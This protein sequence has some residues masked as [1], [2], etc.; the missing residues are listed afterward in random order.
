MCYNKHM[1]AYRHNSELENLKSVT[2]FLIAANVLW[3]L[4]VTV[5]GPTESSDVLIRW[6]ALYTPYVEEGAW[7]RLLSCMFL[8]SGIRHLMNNMITLFALGAML[9]NEAGPVKYMLIYFLGGIAGSA[10]EYAL[11]LRRGEPV[12]AVGAS[13]AVFAVLGGLIW[14]LIANKGRIPGMSIRRLLI[15]AALSIYFGFAS[16]GV[17]NGAHIGGMIAGFLISL[18]LYRKRDVGGE[19][20]FTAQS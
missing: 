7:W 18:L 4:F 20:A 17:A 2:G 14:V 16:G 3:F 10:A 12:V 19:N 1:D 15:Y 5:F 8:H 6:G 11:S 13:G 9:E